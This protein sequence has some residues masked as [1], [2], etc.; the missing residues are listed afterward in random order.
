MRTWWEPFAILALGIIA[1]II[2]WNHILFMRI[3]AILFLGMFMFMS[4][5]AIM[6]KNDYDIFRSESEEEGK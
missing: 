6:V 1:I 4:A 3:T 5:I 2:S